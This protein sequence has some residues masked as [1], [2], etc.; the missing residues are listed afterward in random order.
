MVP[1]RGPKPDENSVFF[2]SSVFEE[3]EPEELK[4]LIDGEEVTIPLNREKIPPGTIA[5][6]RTFCSL[7]L[8]FRNLHDL[9]G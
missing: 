5:G 9:H 1:I 8:Y 4:A 7:F 6:Q 2:T 3:G